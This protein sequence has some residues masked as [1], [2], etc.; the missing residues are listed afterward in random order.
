MTKRSARVILPGLSY[1]LHYLVTHLENVVCFSFFCPQ[2]H[3]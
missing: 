1:Y 2:T 3:R